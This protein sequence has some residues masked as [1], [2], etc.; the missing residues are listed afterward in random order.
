MNIMTSIDNVDLECMRLAVEVA[1]QCKPEKPTD[2]YVGAVARL[3][4]GTIVSAFRGERL[5][6]Y[7]K[8]QSAG[9]HAEYVLLEKK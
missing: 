6:T 5:A 7:E 3:R 2:P 8:P 9:D 1:K 4:D